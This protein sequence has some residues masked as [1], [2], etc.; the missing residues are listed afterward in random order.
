MKKIEFDTIN[1]TREV[2]EFQDG[3]CYYGY[4][5]HYGQICSIL[6]HHPSIII[7]AM[8]VNNENFARIQEEYG[9]E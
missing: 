4:L 2:T 1:G 3:I 7:G 9:V 8:T 5:S 6:N